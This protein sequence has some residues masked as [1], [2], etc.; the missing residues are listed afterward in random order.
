[1]DTQTRTHT[2]NQTR[3]VKY[4][5]EYVETTDGR[6]GVVTS[7]AVGRDGVINLVVSRQ[8]FQSAEEFSTDS[9]RAFISRRR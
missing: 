7:S 5:G 8:V 2:E 1:M 6:N 3:A 9:E 4:V